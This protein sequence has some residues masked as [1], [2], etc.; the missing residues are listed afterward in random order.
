MIGSRQSWR[1]LLGL[2]LPALLLVLA[3]LA[4][5]STYRFLLAGQAQLR[6]AKLE[7]LGGELADLER[8]RDEVEALLA[9]AERNQQQVGELYDSWLSTQQ[10]RLTRVLAEVR[11]LAQRA[12]VETSGFAYPEEVI[13]DFELVKR[14]IVF[15]VSGSYRQLRQFINLV[16]LSDQFLILEE[17]RLS[18]RGN[19]TAE[20]KIDLR[21]A[22]LFVVE[23]PAQAGNVL[24][25]ATA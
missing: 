15:S 20:V 14:S 7:R 6:T 18:D 3:N 25:G 16:E 12:G 13:E 2:W 4:V 24:G 1:R 8:G 23:T 11:T 21:I 17:V 9:I 5:L 22:T 10:K 19:D